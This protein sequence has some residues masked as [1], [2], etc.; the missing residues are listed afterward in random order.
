MAESGLVAFAQIK[1]A[2]IN[3]S[4]FGRLAE[5][6]GLEVLGIL[7][8]DLGLVAEH[9]MQVLADQKARLDG[10]ATGDSAADFLVLVNNLLIVEPL[11]GGAQ[12]AEALQ[13]GIGRLEPRPHGAA[14]RDV[15][16]H[17]VHE[18]VA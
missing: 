8:Q 14:A 4:L 9:H 5:L 2:K 11:R 1:P 12:P 15:K 7:V 6:A 13:V 17:A 3:L 16:D 10:V 18:V